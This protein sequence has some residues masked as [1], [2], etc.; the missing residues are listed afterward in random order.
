[1]I[2]RRRVGRSSAASVQAVSIMSFVSFV[3][4]G[5]VIVVILFGSAML[6]MVVAHFLPPQHLSAETKGV[7][8]AAV[9]GTMSALVIGLLIS[10]SSASFTSKTQEVTQ[11]STEVINLDR[12]L[13]RYGPDTQDSVRCCAD[14]PRRRCRTCSRRIRAK[15]PT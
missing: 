1:M 3:P 6:A 11:I 13:R 4:I 8:S 15:V 9:V 5:V 2:N 10:S 12:M 7:V 14:M